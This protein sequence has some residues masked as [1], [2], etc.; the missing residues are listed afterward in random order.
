MAFVKKAGIGKR[1]AT[2]AVEEIERFSN[3][4]GCYM[5]DIYLSIAGVMSAAQQKGMSSMQL[6]DLEENIAKILYYKWKDFDVAGT[7]TW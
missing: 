1:I 3:G 2:D 6:L 7:I 5:D 4:S